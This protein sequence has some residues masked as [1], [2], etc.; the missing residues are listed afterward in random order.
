MFG[1]PRSG[2]WDISRRNL[3]SDAADRS[4]AYPKGTA[5]TATL[6]RTITG[7]AGSIPVQPVTVAESGTRLR[8]RVA[9]G[10]FFGAAVLSMA[11]I[12]ATPFEGKA[13]E[14]VYLK[15]LMAHPKQAMIAA[16]LLHF[17]YLLFV[18][19]SFVMARLA[20]RGAKK[21]SYAGITLAVLGS[22]LSGLLFTDL[23]DLSIARHV[24]TTVGSPISE[25]QGVP[26]AGVAVVSMALLSSVGMT[27]G[28]SLLAG[29][30]RR[31]RLAPIWPSIGVFAGFLTAFGAHGLIRSATGFGLMCAS[32]GYVG[33]KVL[34]MSDERFAYGSDP[35]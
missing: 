23:Y 16:T 25:M 34:R 11:G 33:V 12:L 35:R 24:G 9:A 18:P 19:A 32:I 17:G 29:A 10:T 21:L 15:S 2:A 6:D 30:M 4:A 31:A 13:G 22:G 5:M 1:T 28:L 26:F 7:S 8:R 27:F 3:S 14:A 20:R